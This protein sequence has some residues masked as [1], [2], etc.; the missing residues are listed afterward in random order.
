MPRPTEAPT[1]QRILV[2][3]LGAIGDVVRTRVAF[4][5]LRSLYPSARIEWLVEDLARTALDGLVGLDGIYTVPRQ[6]LSFWNR[7]PRV[8]RVVR[9][10]RARRYDLVVDFH[11]ILKSALLV[12]ASGAPVR[13]GYDG[14]VARESSHRFYTHR[15]ALRETHVSRFERNAALVEYLGGKVPSTA[16]P[17]ALSPDVQREIDGADLPAAP[18]V[19]HPGTSASTR[20]KRWSS[21]RYAQVARA[22]RDAYGWRT[23]VSWGP[24]SGEREVAER[25]VAASDGAAVLAPPTPSVA[26]LLALLTG[27]RLFVGADSGPMHVAGLAGCPLVALYGP[28]DPVENAPSP[29]VPARVLRRDVGCNPCREG[30]PS[31]VCLES[32]PVDEVV[33]AAGSLVAGP[34]PVR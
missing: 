34:S 17:V 28:T 29:G 31:R 16:P 5:G 2:V 18:V 26:H 12:R 20:Y 13:I 14:P 6:G 4:A 25:V 3:R 21:D 10:L 9:E 8:V 15:V 32:I 1:A 7:V 27:A 30:C 23:V 24:V 19:M 33:R 22:L 11:G